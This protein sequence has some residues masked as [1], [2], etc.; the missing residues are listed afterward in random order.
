MTQGTKMQHSFVSG[1]LSPSMWGQCSNPK[2]E[3]GASTM[4]NGFVNF[5]GGYSSR[6]GSAYVG[7]CRQNAPNIGTA[8]NN[9]APPRDIPFQF[10]ITQSYVLEFG[11]FYLRIK[12][13]GAYVTETPITVSSVSAAALFTTSGNHGYSVGD[14]VFDSRNT[15]FNVLT[16]IVATTPTA[17]TFTVTDLFG[18]AVTSATPSTGGTVA[19]IYNVASPYAA[20]DLPYL[21]FSQSGNTMYL[22]CWNQQTL[23][24]YAP[25][26]LTRNGPAQWI[27]SQSTFSSSINAPTNVQATAQNSTTLNTWYTYVV[28]SVDATTAGDESVA[29]TMI[30]VQ[31]N[32]ISINAGSNTITW[33]QVSGAGSYNIYAA[34]PYYS[35]SATPIPQIGVTFGFVGSSLG[36]SFVDNNITPDFTT[37]PPLQTNPFARSP[38]TFVNPTAGGSGLS[39]ATAN[40]TITTSTGSGFAGTPIISSGGNLVG[41]YNKNDGAG[42]AGSDTIAIVTGGSQATG[43]YT[44][45]GSQPSD[46]QTIILNSVTWTF[47]TTPTSPAQTQIQSTLPATFKQLAFDLGASGNTLLTAATYAS[48]GTDTLTITY[49]EIGTVGNAYTLNTGSYNGTISGST[50]TGGSNGTVSNAT[51]SLVIGPKSGTYPGCNAFFQ[52]R[53]AYA[54][55]QNSPN[56]YF[57]SQPGNF[58]N[59]N[60]SV[61]VVASDAITGTPWAQQVNGIQF[62][63]PMP[64]GL[65]IFTGA[66]AW[67]LSGGPTVAITPADQDVQPQSRYG[68]SSTVP[69]IPINFHLLFV[70]ENNG[71]VYDLVYNFWANIYIGNDLTIYSSH[72]FGTYGYT[73]TQWAY[74]EKPYKTVWTVR[75]DGAMLSLTYSAEQQEE[76]WARHDTN[77]LYVGVCSV[78][79]PPVDAV[80]VIVQR[81]VNGG[82]VYYS[83]RFDNRIWTNPE[84]C[85]CV[86]A[87]LSYPMTFPNATLTASSATGT[88][89]ITSTV[90]IQGGSYPN[91]DAVAVAQDSTGA[92]SGATFTVSYSGNAISAVTPVA[93][94]TKYTP[95]S[96]TITITSPTG[97]TGAIIEPIITDNVTFT[98][99]ASAFTSGMVGNVIRMGN[100][101]A[102]IVTYNSVTSVVGN[103]T[104][105]ITATVPNDPNNTPLP[106]TANN[107][108]ISVPTTTVS[109]LNHLNGLQVTG[110]ADGGVIPLTTVANG[111]I[112]LPQTASAINVGLPFLPQLQSLQLEIPAQDTSQTKRKNIPAVGVR[113]HNSRGFSIGSNQPDA[114]AQPGQANV[115]WSGMYPVK[116]MNQ[117]TIMGQPIP[118][119][120]RDYY[121]EGLSDWS[122]KGQ[123]AVQQPN[124]LPLNVDAIVYYWDQGD[125][126]TP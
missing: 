123:I 46:G 35:T 126:N 42:Y 26:T 16:W 20:T 31:N 7:M 56:T 12:Y 86:D 105:P 89:N 63:V 92:G 6:A 11:D 84:N 94:G 44:G 74:A 37:T 3:T 107:W 30:Q 119:Q 22:T 90:V 112:T 51:A 110:L 53:L 27:F 125:T 114:S 76:G 70:R 32:N 57:M 41:F 73:I 71:V 28:T 108:S 97:G 93:N 64:G 40:F 99:S 83:E 80:Y 111:S 104:A 39:Q 65:V 68:C 48:S 62:M 96:T 2:Y 109:G 101:K 124:P 88:S 102:T 14:W 9:Q 49:A 4:R 34:A 72:L 55:T 85:F 103:L 13:L 81:Y 25:Y 117:S 19:R 60:V 98:A 79:E 38:I 33:N 58:T 15:G 24:E 23:T 43:T 87:G 113:V 95:G 21:K 77:G 91:L 78:E 75:N 100:G 10:S 121:Q 118:L 59:M 17:S 18:A 36:N 47:K 82:W 1:E 45:A 61:P 8:N 54:M 106:Q 29:S 120:T 52:E 116:D 115:A 67:Q 50:L 122:T 69:P 5:Q 66:G